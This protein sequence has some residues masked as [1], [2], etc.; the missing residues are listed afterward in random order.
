MPNRLK[1]IEHDQNRIL[2]CL[3]GVSNGRVVDIA[4]SFELVYDE[5]E[6]DIVIDT[7]FLK[8]R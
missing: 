8:T 4:N 6:G 5:V 3:L 2:G 1:K 7:E